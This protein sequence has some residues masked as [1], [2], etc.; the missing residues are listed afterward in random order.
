LASP[1]S[2]GE[3]IFDDGALGGGGGAAQVREGGGTGGGAI[4]GVGGGTGGGT[5]KGLGTGADTGRGTGAA[6]GC[7]TGGG[8]VGVGCSGSCRCDRLEVDCSS[9]FLKLDTNW[10]LKAM[11]TDEIRALLKIILKIMNY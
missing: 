7:G 9:L 1:E 11:R 5:M 6:T 4:T 2:S 3:Y 8:G 10:F